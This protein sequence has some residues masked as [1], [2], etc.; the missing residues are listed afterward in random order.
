GTLMYDVAVVGGGPT[1]GSA[2]V[3]LAKAGLKTLVLDNGRGQTRRA[4]IENHYGFDQ[5]ISGPDLVDGGQRQAEKLG[6]QW[7]TAE[8]TAI[9]REGAGCTLTTEDGR[10][11]QAQQVRL[12]PGPVGALAHAAGLWS[13]H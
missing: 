12:A 3:S 9:A 1:G 5:G 2:A 4:W 11:F 10:T 13:T 8:V 7:V 6:A